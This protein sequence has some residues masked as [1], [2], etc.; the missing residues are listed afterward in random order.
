MTITAEDLRKYDGKRVVVTR[1]LSEPNEKGESAVE[2][3][4]VVQAA[5]EH[6]LLIKPKGQVQFK[7]IPS[8]EIEE[9]RL[10]ED[11]S[12]KLKAS[13]LNIVKLGSA[14]RHLLERHG[15]TLDW[16]NGVTEEQAYEHHAEIDHVENDLGH[17]HVEK[18]DKDAE[19]SDE[20]ASDE[21]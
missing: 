5:N 21:E 13:K 17:V 2:V 14:R 11:K 18:K 19:A 8:D 7:L 15:Y 16:V 1:N 20:S 12:N 3:E 10:Q 9:V 6:G 4:G